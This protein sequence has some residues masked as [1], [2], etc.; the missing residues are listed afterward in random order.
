MNI[1]ENEVTTAE[2]KS[3]YQRTG[4]N[5]I[6]YSFE[7]AMQCELTK[8]CLVRMALNAQKKVTVVSSNKKVIATATPSPT[9][10][11]WQE[12]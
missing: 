5:R 6:G 10:Y 2:L 1:S 11:W 9:H 7:K 3:A 12:L 4:L 8:K